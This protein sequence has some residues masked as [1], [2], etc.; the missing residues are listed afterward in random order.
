[1]IAFGLATLP[2]KP[3]IKASISFNLNPVNS[4]ALPILK[5]VRF[6]SAIKLEGVATPNKQKVSR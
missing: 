6:V 5:G 1:M 3:R 4:I 2:S